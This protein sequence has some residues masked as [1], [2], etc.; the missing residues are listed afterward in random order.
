MK[1]KIN[2]ELMIQRKDWFSLYHES[3]QKKHAIMNKLDNTTNQNEMGTILSINLESPINF[4]SESPKPMARLTAVFH[5]LCF[6]CIDS[7]GL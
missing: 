2:A 4:P 5:E 7:S 6:M 3:Y 1:S